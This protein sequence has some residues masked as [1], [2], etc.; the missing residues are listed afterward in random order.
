MTEIKIEDLWQHCEKCGGTGRIVERS[1]SFGITETIEQNCPEC[2]GRG[3]KI[4]S[5]GDSVVKFIGQ[6]K[7]LGILLI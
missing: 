7:R 6:M 4:T 3:G 1:G 5:S 2:G